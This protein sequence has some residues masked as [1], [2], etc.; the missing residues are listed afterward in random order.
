M[1][2]SGGSQ[3]EQ[4]G[5]AA[6]PRVLEP[7]VLLISEGPNACIA[8]SAPIYDELERT[9]AAEPGTRWVVVC[10]LRNAK[11]PNAEYRRYLRTRIQSLG[12]AV[13]A[14]EICSGANTL[15]NAAV[16]FVLRAAMGSTPFSVHRTLDAAVQAARTRLKE[17]AEEAP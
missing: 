13:L 3:L 2:D 15:I 1:R 8:S 12:E 11:R 7:G 16:Q 10:D 14:W 6:P 4:A 9:M 17:H 5:T